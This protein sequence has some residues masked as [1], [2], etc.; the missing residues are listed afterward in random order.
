MGRPFKT[1]LALMAVLALGEP[2][3][4]QRKSSHTTDGETATGT[5]APGGGNRGPT[6]EPTGT[7]MMAPSLTGPLSGIRAASP[8]EPER[9]AR[10]PRAQASNLGGGQGG[11]GA[12]EPD[13]CDRANLQKAATDLGDS[14]SQECAPLYWYVVGQLLRA[15]ERVNAYRFCAHFLGGKSYAVLAREASTAGTPQS[16]DTIAKTLKR[17]ARS[18]VQRMP[19]LADCRQETADDFLQLGGTTKG[20]RP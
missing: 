15:G 4:A 18:Y 9:A 11:G 17:R 20:A 7:T 16:R 12:P 14:E 1:A 2:A 13:V 3:Q 19:R 6:G 5:G 10:M 8:P